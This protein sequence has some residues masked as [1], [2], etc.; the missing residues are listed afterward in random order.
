MQV[1][2]VKSQ[3]TKPT[4]VFRN[5]FREGSS[6]ALLCSPAFSALWLE[7]VKKARAAAA[8]SRVATEGRK[9]IGDRPIFGQNQF[10]LKLFFK[11][12]VDI[13]TIRWNTPRKN[14]P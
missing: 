9:E 2:A 5:L 7:Q 4:V 8:V 10:K 3:F 14:R 11:K 1:Y 13:V 12:F 6:V